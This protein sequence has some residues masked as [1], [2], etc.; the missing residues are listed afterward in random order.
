M[1]TRAEANLTR[2][3]CDK[4]R[5]AIVYGALDLGEPLSENAL[6]RALGMSKAPIRAAMG[7]LRLKGLVHV[8]PQSGTYVFSPTREEIEQLCD[9][10]FLLE[11]QALQSSMASA[12][13]DFVAALA[14]VVAEMDAAD[15]TR[16]KLLDSEFHHLFIR[17][18]GNGYL[19]DA[20]ETIAHRVE[21]LRYRFMDTAV[22]RQKAAAEHRE[23]LDLLSAGRIAKAVGV[24]G[25]HIARTREFQSRVTWSH[26]RSRR[27][28]YKFREHA[29]VFKDDLVPPGAD[30][31][32]P[33]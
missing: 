10:R 29:I 28:D 24:L 8:V 32:P 21:A 18:C 15:G 19:T 1:S 7:E 2:V 5:A 22:Y 4:I 3:A 20:Y 17:Y 33:R 13:G 26:G 30:D 27:S 31:V 9:F 14:R 25:E 6:A 23:M 16:G 12:A 11:G